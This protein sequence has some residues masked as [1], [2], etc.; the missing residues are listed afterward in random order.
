VGLRAVADAGIAGVYLYGGHV[1]ALVI[2]WF[3]LGEVP[4]W[5]VI[6]SGVLAIVGVAVG[7]TNV[8]L[9]SQMPCCRTRA[10]GT[11]ALGRSGRPAESVQTTD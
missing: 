7:T 2:A 11:G 6:V 8:S 5:L 1:A 10:G 9:S 4:E 3:W